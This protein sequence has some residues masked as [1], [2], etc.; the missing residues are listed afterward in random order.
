M[1]GHSTIF[2]FLISFCLGTVFPRIVSA[3]EYIVSAKFQFLTYYAKE[4]IQRKTLFK[5]INYMR[6]YCESS[7]F[8]SSMS[9]SKV[10][11]KPEVP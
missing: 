9:T 4:I 10:L 8:P 1:R 2:F 3:L 5:G 6:K 7:C 11:L